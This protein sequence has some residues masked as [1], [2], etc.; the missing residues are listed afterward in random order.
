[1]RKLTFCVV[2][3]MTFMTVALPVFGDAPSEQPITKLYLD[4]EAEEGII[5]LLGSAKQTIDIQMYGMTLYPPIIDALK[6]AMDNNVK[7]RIYLDTQGFNNPKKTD[8][9]G[10]PE[11]D[12]ES[13]KPDLQAEVRWDPKTGTLMHRKVAVIDG[14]KIWIG[15]TN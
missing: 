13:Y 12:I 6:K 15:S 4:N 10:F 14:Y 7:I 2:L 9:T 5:E 1:M 8:E 3:L 11:P